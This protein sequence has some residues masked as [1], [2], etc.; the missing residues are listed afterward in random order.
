MD[1]SELHKGFNLGFEGLRNNVAKVFTKLTAVDRFSLVEEFFTQFINT[2]NTLL[3][4]LALR[5]SWEKAAYVGLD[6]GIKCQTVSYSEAPVEDAAKLRGTSRELF[7]LYTRLACNVLV[8]H[9]DNQV[10][11]VLSEE[12]HLRAYGINIKVVDNVERI[13]SNLVDKPVSLADLAI[14]CR[15]LISIIY[16]LTKSVAL[17]E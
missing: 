2:E 11:Q 8:R 7:Y 13:V 3:E 5:G 14:A 16:L 9:L 6:V 12:L 17:K 4:L 10:V 1:L 15:L